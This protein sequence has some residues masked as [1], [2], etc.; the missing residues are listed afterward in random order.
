[1]TAAA[2]TW[3]TLWPALV[4]LG[5]LLLAAPLVPGVA[6]RTRALLTGRRGP[7]VWQLYADLGKL[8][9]KGTVYSV[10][11]TWI[12]RLAPLALVATTVA[13]AAIVPLNG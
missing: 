4:S 1:M 6:T 12:F 8:L 9:R 3:D 10:T 11:T 5:V 13:A 2:S 7:P